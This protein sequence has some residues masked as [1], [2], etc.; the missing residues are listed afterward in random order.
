MLENCVKNNV[1]ELKIQFFLMR[2]YF[3]VVTKTVCSVFDL[4]PSN[5]QDYGQPF[6]FLFVYSSHEDE[7]WL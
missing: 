6:Q 2:N 1:H 4:P 3:M 5:T 7:K